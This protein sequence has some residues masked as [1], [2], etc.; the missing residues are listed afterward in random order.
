MQA[1]LGA[2]N[3]SLANPI[4]INRF[5]PNILVRAIRPNLLWHSCQ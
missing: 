3:A 1:S 4:P 2:L 5:R